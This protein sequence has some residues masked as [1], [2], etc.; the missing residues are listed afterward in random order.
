MNPGAGV[1]SL[2]ALVDWYAALSKFREDTQNGVTS[3]ALALQR[4]FD[5][6]AEQQQEWRREIRAAEDA[7]V[8][9]KNDLR[10]KQY[11][12]WL[13]KKP[14]TTVEEKNLRK[15]LARLEFAEDR[16]ETTRRWSQR[17]PR[18]IQDTYD[19]PTRSLSFFLDTDMERALAHLGQQINVLEQYVNMQG[20]Q[21]SAPQARGEPDP[22]EPT[23]GGSTPKEQP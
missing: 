17:L 5:W 15:A 14:D 11:E 20:P 9:A 1:Q 2:D 21:T 22:V 18:L 8:Q 13:G 7:V 19:G 3:M 16:L 6:L 12:D 10:K 4:C 23:S